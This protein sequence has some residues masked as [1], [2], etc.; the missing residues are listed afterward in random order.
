VALLALWGMKTI[1]ESNWARDIAAGKLYQVPNPSVYEDNG[2]RTQAVLP[3][4]TDVLIVPHYASDYLAAY[5]NVIDLAHPGNAKWNELTSMYAVGYRVLPTQLQD[6]FCH[7]LL[8]YMRQNARFL[9]QGEER[10]WLPIFDMDELM[11]VCHQDLVAASDKRI[12]AMVRQLKSLK[13]D[14]TYG[15]FRNS[16]LQRNVI[17]Q[18]LEHWNSVLVPRQPSPVRQT[19]STISTSMMPHKKRKIMNAT[20]TRGSSNGVK[21]RYT[22]PKSGEPKEPFPLAWIREG[23]I[24][25]ALYRCEAGFYYR[26][27][28]LAA[29]ASDATFHVHFDDGDVNDGLDRSCLRRWKPL[30][31]GERIQVRKAEDKELWNDGVIIAT[32]SNLDNSVSVDVQTAYGVVTGITTAD[33]RRHMAFQQGDEVS[34]FDQEDKEWYPAKILDLGMKGNYVVQYMDGEIESGVATERI[35]R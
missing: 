9:K 29:V 10:E 17:P 34:V 2:Y 31:V 4:E 6:Q 30:R 5:G 18:L 19:K 23:D 8:D 1:D 14:T 11:G 33:I 21:R 13:V 22:I 16:A 12:A 28:V 26:G 27:T 35:V 15:R 24:V 25:E 3:T 20:A 7:F 32:R